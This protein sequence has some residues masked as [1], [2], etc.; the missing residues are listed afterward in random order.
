MLALSPSMLSTIGWPLEESL[1]GHETTPDDSQSLLD[2]QYY[3]PP[4]IAHPQILEPLHA[5]TSYG[6]GDEVPKDNSKKLNHNASER[7]RRTKIN[8]LYSSLRSLLPPDDQK[9][10]LSVPAT[11]DRVIKYIPELQ[12]QVERLVGKKEKLCARLSRDLDQ[13]VDHHHHDREKKLKRKFNQ[14]SSFAVST[15]RISDTEVAVQIST[16]KMHGNPILLLSHIIY[17]LEEDELLLINVNSSESSGGIVFYNLHLQV[18]R[19]YKMESAVLS[20]KLLS[21]HEK[22]SLL[23]YE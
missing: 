23:F 8:C 3:L 2:D 20:E 15:A 1:I 18:E 21:L 19:S 6:T 16:L 11:V 13:V 22:G 10:K 4:P 7:H 5:F 17:S 12:Q 9:K 14:T